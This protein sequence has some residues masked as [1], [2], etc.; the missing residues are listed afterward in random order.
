MTGA[1]RPTSAPS[2]RPSLDVDWRKIDVLNGGGTPIHEP[3]LQEII[4]RNRKA[5]RSTFS[6]DVRSGAS[7][8][9]DFQVIAVSTPSDEDGSADLQYDTR[10]GAHYRPRIRRASR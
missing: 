2:V 9:R 5:G 8:M 3:G 6:T 7:R 4:A 1:Y 10:R